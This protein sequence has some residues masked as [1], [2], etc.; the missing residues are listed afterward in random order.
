MY[1]YR[2][3]SLK[4]ITKE[5]LKEEFPDLFNIDDKKRIE[6]IK[7]KYSNL[8]DGSKPYPK[9]IQKMIKGKWLDINLS[10]ILSPELY[11]LPEH[12]NKIDSL[13]VYCNG[14]LLNNTK[15]P[16]KI[17]GKTF[18]YATP[19]GFYDKGH[20]IELQHI[21]TS[22]LMMGY[23]YRYPIYIIYNFFY[24]PQIYEE[25]LEYSKKNFPSIGDTIKKEDWEPFVFTH[26]VEWIGGLITPLPLNLIKI[27]RYENK[28]PEIPYWFDE[29]IMK[30]NIY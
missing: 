21:L 8:F 24:L 7:N 13:R 10:E 9:H 25:Y 23:V 17:I 20:I 16:C 3:R 14:H 1:N 5:E 2:K 28:L 18:S 26:E 15:N 11:I 30:R 6:L 19:N 27:K 12:A 22:E 29:F 4:P